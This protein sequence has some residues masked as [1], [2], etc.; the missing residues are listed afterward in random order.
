M[1]LN[2]VISSTPYPH[3]L[4]GY[5]FLY[6]S[7]SDLSKIILFVKMDTRFCIL[8]LA[9]IDLGDQE[10]GIALEER[11]TFD[12]SDFFLSLLEDLTVSYVAVSRD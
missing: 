12:V 8:V 11:I 3:L 6:T 1:V 10:L 9:V 7:L 5:T 2:H 4:I